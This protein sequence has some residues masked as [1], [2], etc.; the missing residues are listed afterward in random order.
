MHDST[1]VD[2]VL[3]YID[4]LYATWC[5]KPDA[6]ALSPQCL[7]S[8]FIEI[9]CLREFM[10]SGV[11]TLLPD[12]G[13][14]RFLAHEHPEIGVRL[15]TTDRGQGDA[16]PDRAKDAEVFA[17]FVKCWNRFLASEYRMSPASGETRSGEPGE[18][19]NRGSL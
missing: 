18:E 10:L 4:D 1:V 6:Y 11:S 17:E 15:F 2:R 14:L 16:S 19:Q 8:V 7:E 9:E 12:C 13:Y 5:R 3:G